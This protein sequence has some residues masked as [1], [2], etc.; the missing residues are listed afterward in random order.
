MGASLWFDGA[1]FLALVYRLVHL[2]L[3]TKSA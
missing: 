1:M 2:S 3:P